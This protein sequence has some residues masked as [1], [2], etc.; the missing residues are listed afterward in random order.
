MK[1]YL[2]AAYFK[3][4]KTEIT[5]KE[6]ENLLKKLNQ[7]LGYY[8]YVNIWMSIRSG[9][10]IGPVTV[11]AKGPAVFAPFAFQCCFEILT[12]YSHAFALA[13]A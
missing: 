1:I 11:P 13:A 9:F 10:P 2:L 12:K 4:E 8:R 5:K 6:I 7:E 3:G